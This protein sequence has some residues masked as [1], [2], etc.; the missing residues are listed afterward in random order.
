MSDS[1]LP[2][3]FV[4]KYRRLMGSEAD[5]F[6]S[7]LADERTF[8]VRIND[9]KIT[10]AEFESRWEAEFGEVPRPIP[11]VKGGYYY[12]GSAVRPGHS[13]A[14]AQ[15]LFY[16]QDPSAMYPAAAAEPEPGMRVLDLCSAPGGKAIQMASRMAGRGILYCNDISGSRIKAL[17][18]NLE[19]FGV[20]NAVV[21]NESPDKLAPAFRGYF[22]VVV[23]DVPCSG[24]G[25]F[26]KDRGSVNEW[27]RHGS[28]R[29]SGLQLSILSGAAEMTKP[30]GRIIYSTC[31][32]APEE[33]EMVLEAFL[34]SNPEFVMEPLP[35]VAGQEGGRTEWTACGTDMTGAVRMWPHRLKGEG[36]FTAK[37]TKRPD[38][39]AGEAPRMAVLKSDD[40][41]MQAFESFA[42]AALDT[43]FD[44]MVFFTVGS[45]L[46]ALPEA[47]VRLDGLRVSKF[48][49]YLG[50]ADHGK[51]TPSQSLASAL[52]SGEIRGDRLIDLEYG[53]REAVSYLKCETPLFDAPA[54]G[55]SAVAIGGIPS[56]WVKSDGVSVKNIYPAGWRMNF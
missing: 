6:F 9:L 12:D 29:L 35:K 19:Q 47:P 41:V 34:R 26:R 53:S 55:Y 28:E 50:S 46:Y 52:R 42:D 2:E 24:E 43:R 13:I 36:H 15:G 51:F 33:D 30:G 44:G 56:G 23:T 31:T 10:P 40:K 49:W 8:G 16:I 21:L 20:R 22:D 39:P 11:W 27:D 18:R 17:I 37:L 5:G 38:A 48:G 3:Q 7:A 45:G 32:Y 14:F 54:R 4:E 1:Y 25:M